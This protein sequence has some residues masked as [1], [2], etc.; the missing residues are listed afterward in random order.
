MK[1]SGNNYIVRKKGFSTGLSFHKLKLQGKFFVYFAGLVI[2]VVSFV[3][4][5]V[6]YFQ[7]QM[8]L[9]QAQEKAFSLARSLAYTSLNSILQDDYI[10]VQ[11]LID[12]M[13]D[14][15]D[16]QSIAILDSTGRII[17]SS[18][19]QLRGHLQNDPLTRKA[20]SSETFLLQ[21]VPNSSGKEL[22]D[23]AVPIFELNHR[24]G[25]ARIKYSVED[26]YQ[27]LLHTVVIIGVLAIALSLGL[28]Y[29]F[30]GSIS[31]P[32]RKAAR[33]ASEYGKGNLDASISLEREDEIGDL[34]ISLNKLSHELQTLIDEKIANEKLILMGEFAAYIIHD[35]KNPLSGI[36]LLSDGLHRK[37]PEDS[38]LK[39][40]STEIL[41]ATQKLQDFVERTLDIARW[42]KLDLRPIQ[43]PALIEE[44]LQD[45]DLSFCK[46]TKEC[47]PEMP[48][49]Y[50]D[51]Q[52]LLMAIKNLLINAVEAMNGQGAIK[53]TTI[54]KNGTIIKI[55]D[56]G[57]GI[58]EEKIKSIFRP[59]YSMKKQGHGLGLAMV[60]KAVLMHHGRIDVESK[61]GEGSVFII[62]LP[63]G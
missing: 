11:M 5:A 38:Q 62:S 13:M 28:S 49:I 48:E 22:W 24:L 23:T 26:T 27:G 44:A 58:P 47:D 50:G 9:K 61:V 59:F 56:T 57:S 35:L 45:V 53:I 37:L 32:I 25:T 40:Y 16:V 63:E 3:M 18:T 17:A 29:K 51:Q 7:R 15:A 55:S 46:V 34:V 12:S 43:L 41:L 6:F 36:R 14:D 52:M 2:V 21:K 10:V 54:R 1:K 31:D 33:L 4:I 30:S 39:K 42:T 8:L 19:P 20:L 60:K